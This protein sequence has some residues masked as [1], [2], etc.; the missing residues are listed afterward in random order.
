MREE[1]Q[2]VKHKDTDLYL[3]LNIPTDY[4]K[5]ERHS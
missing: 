5:R 2:L 4:K 1:D 3:Q